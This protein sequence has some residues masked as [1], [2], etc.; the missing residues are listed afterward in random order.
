MQSKRTSL[1]IRKIEIQVIALK[2][3]VLIYEIR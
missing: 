1:G 2:L 3:N